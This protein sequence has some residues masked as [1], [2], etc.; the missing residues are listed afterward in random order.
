MQPNMTELLMLL[1]FV[2]RQTAFHQPYIIDY[3]ADII[4][5]R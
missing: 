3:M 4:N 1:C 5:T 2:D